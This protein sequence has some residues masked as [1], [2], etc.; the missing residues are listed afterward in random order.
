M[1]FDTIIKEYLK[2]I[3]KKQ[4]K[5]GNN[6]YFTVVDKNIQNT[7]VYKTKIGNKKN[8]TK[9]MKIMK[10]ELLIVLQFW[11]KNYVKIMN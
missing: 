5:R 4:S 6:E 1:I 2:K 9:V 7:L 10:M 11:N 8:I 3:D